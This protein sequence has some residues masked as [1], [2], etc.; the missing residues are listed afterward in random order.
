MLSLKRNYHETGNGCGVVRKEIMSDNYYHLGNNTFIVIN[1][2]KGV[3]R[4]HI[5]EY[6][7]YD[8]NKCYPTRNGV[9]FFYCEFNFVC[10]VL[11]D[12]ELKFEN[13]SLW[14][15][16]Y[17]EI[18]TC[19]DDIKIFTS[20][21]EGDFKLIISKTFYA[22]KEITTK[23]ELSIEQVV[24]LISI[25]MKMKS[26]MIAREYMLRLDQLLCPLIGLESVRSIDFKEVNKTFGTVFKKHIQAKI[27]DSFCVN[28][29]E[30]HNV[31]IEMDVSKIVDEVCHRH[32]NIL[33]SNEHL[34]CNK[35]VKDMQF[36]FL[37]NNV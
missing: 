33:I 34:D 15:C 22:N 18:S 5:R 17:E 26:M 6:Q 11:Q 8:G 28:I 30:L 3:P 29:Q 4:A 27:K 37:D 13:S 9:S 1:D 16:A 19:M 21:D 2:Y 36:V 31:L 12:L 35:L 7:C 25:C 20:R 10:E 23:I 14:L 24:T 32:E